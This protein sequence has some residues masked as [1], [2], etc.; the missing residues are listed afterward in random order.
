MSLQ[1]LDASTLR[2][3]QLSIVTLVSS[4][5]LLGQPVIVFFVGAV[6][7]AGA[8]NPKLALFKRFYTSAVR[9]ALR[10]EP[11]LVDDDPRPHNFAQGLGG[12]FLLAAS[13]AFGL[14]LPIIGW[15]L[16]AA[17]VALALLS[18]TTNICV[19]CFLYYQWRTRTRARAS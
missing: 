2:F 6:L 12:V 4:A 9:P 16:S 1:R 7:L 17:V 14:G 10:L 5:A 11:R 13:L 3:N 19:G 8:L 18:L 15:G